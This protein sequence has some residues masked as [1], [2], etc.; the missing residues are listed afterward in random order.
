MLLCFSFHMHCVLYNSLLS[1]H[2]TTGPFLTSSK[3]DGELTRH[4]SVWVSM[5]TS[6]KVCGWTEMELV[7]NPLP[8]LD[9]SIS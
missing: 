2:Q 5:Q 4:L 1:N 3:L 8:G 7:R 6:A 9:N